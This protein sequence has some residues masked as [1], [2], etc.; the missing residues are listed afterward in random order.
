M[1]EKNSK[2]CGCLFFSA[3]ALARNLTRIAEEEYQVTGLSPSHAL[4]LLTINEKQG[5]HPKELAGEMQ[6]TPSTVTRL[7]D[8]LESR[9]YIIREEKGKTVK[10]FSTVKGKAMNQK[11]KSAWLRLYKRYIGVTG[12][13][14]GKKMTHWIYQ[15]AQKLD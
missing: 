15:T 13:E 10:V 11:I 1:V 3:N 5:I 12:P 14:E 6:L 2:Y 4:G 7:L 9:K 8:K